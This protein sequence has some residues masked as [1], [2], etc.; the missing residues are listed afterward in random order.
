MGSLILDH[1]RFHEIASDYAAIYPLSHIDDSFKID[2]DNVSLPQS[3]QLEWD[4][5][6]RTAREALN[7]KIRGEKLKVS[8]QSAR[9]LSSLINEAQDQSFSI[10]WDDILPHFRY[11]DYVR[12][13]P[14]IF[15]LTHETD[16]TL[17]KKPLRYRADEITLQ[18]D[19]S[20]E[21]AFDPS[22]LTSLQLTGKS[23][24]EQVKNEKVRCSRESFSLIQSVRSKNGS[25]LG[26]LEGVLGTMLEVGCLQL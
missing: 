14:P 17:S 13:Q 16:L 7:E 24:L 15:P 23:L 5:R 18:P 20:Q 10:N 1:A 12:I 19:S 22:P 25:I 9:F 21:I 8:K 4:D 3:I 11:F 6:L 2:L 26:E